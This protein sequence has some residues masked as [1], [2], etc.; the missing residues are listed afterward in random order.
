M[1]G[2]PTVHKCPHAE[3]KA[4]LLS[5]LDTLIAPVG[6]LVAV[7]AGLKFSWFLKLGRFGD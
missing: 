6:T 7:F 1:Q 4:P 3:I 2:S 5:G